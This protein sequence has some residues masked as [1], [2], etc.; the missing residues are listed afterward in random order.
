[1]GQE[2]SSSVQSQNNAA[3]AVARSAGAATLEAQVQPLQQRLHPNRR[4]AGGQPMEPIFVYP[5]TF[6]GNI[7]ANMKPTGPPPFDVSQDHLFGGAAQPAQVQPA[8]VAGQAGK[9]AQPSPPVQRAQPKPHSCLACSLFGR[10][11]GGASRRQAAQANVATQAPVAAQSGGAPGPVAGGAAGSEGQ[12]AVEW[13]RQY[14]AEA[15][16]AQAGGMGLTAEQKM[17]LQHE[18]AAH[19]QQEALRSYRQSQKRQLADAQ[20]QQAALQARMAQLTAQSAGYEQV[21]PGMDGNGNGNGL[22]AGGSRSRSRS[23]KHSRLRRKSHSRSKRK[24]KGSKAKGSKAK[25]KKASAR[26]S[27][28]ASLALSR[29]LSRSSRSRSGSRSRSRSHSKSSHHTR[30]SRGSRKRMA[31]GEVPDMTNVGAL[32]AKVA[33]GRHHR[34]H[35][36]RS[37]RFRRSS[38]SRGRTYSWSQPLILRSSLMGGALP[39]NS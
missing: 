35:G 2:Q 7:T 9:A 24:S 20:H 17:R 28:S 10:R 32:P 37:R 29:L 33:A 23:Y 36:S 30:P 12:S 18:V 8:E 19:Q 16:A 26:K 11:A 34:H 38:R 31:G 6:Q 3:P 4:T 5:S 1:M 39:K 25:A 15:K 14:L 21:I 22:V 13:A 27:R